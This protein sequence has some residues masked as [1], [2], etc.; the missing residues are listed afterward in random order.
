MMAWK[1]SLPTAQLD[2]GGQELEVRGSQMVDSRA[3]YDSMTLE[4]DKVHHAVCLDGQMVA[5]RSLR[6]GLV[7]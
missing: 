7:L 5:V 4:G 3:W 2:A 1:M 6:Y